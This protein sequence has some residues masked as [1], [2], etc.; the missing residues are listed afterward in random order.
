MVNRVFYA[1]SWVSLIFAVVAFLISYASFPDEVL[2]FINDMGEPVQYLARNSLF[3]TLLLVL[4]LFNGAWLIIGGI[5]R[6]TRPVLQWTELGISLSQIFF[7]VFFATAVYFVNLLNSRENFDYSNF[8]MLVYLTG[9]LLVA[10][11]IFTAITGL[12]VKK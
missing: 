7:N 3:Y 12:I 5:V 8:G 1:L 2:I 11:M 6:N 10:A 9:G 4:V